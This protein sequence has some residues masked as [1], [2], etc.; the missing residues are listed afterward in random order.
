MDGAFYVVVV[1]DPP[2]YMEYAFQFRTVLATLQQQ[3]DSSVPLQ[4]F[5][6][7]VQRSMAKSHSLIP[8]LAS[9]LK[10]LPRFVRG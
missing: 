10:Q 1:V 6:E 9:P 7:A 8:L 4:Q 3:L 5:L 2:R